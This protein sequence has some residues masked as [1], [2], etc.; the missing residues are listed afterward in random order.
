MAASKNRIKWAFITSL[1]SIGKEGLVWGAHIR[2]PNI[3]TDP[4]MA[5]SP[6]APGK[7][8]FGRAALTAGLAAGICLGLQG[9]S[10]AH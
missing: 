4:T 10:T 9:G 7:M 1:L 3:C 5:P 6:N 2:P 8:H